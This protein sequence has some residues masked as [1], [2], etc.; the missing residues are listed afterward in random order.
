MCIPRNY[1]S[2]NVPVEDVFF[3]GGHSIFLPSRI[4][5]QFP[6]ALLKT[7]K[8]QGNETCPLIGFERVLAC[9]LAG[10]VFNGRT[11]ATLTLEDICRKT[12]QP[13]PLWYNILTDEYEEG[14][15]TCG[16]LAESFRFV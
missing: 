1:F 13:Q 8:L 15:Y 11:C 16:L 5:Q 7:R 12:C 2:E 6:E 3:S 14:M 4:A 10:K 9:G